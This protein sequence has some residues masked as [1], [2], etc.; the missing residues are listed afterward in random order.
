MYNPGSHAAIFRGVPY[1]MSEKTN[2]ITPEATLEGDRSPV[3]AKAMPEQTKD[4]GFL[5]I[6]SHLRFHENRPQKFGIVLQLTFA[7]A[8]MFSEWLLHVTVTIR[9]V[10]QDFH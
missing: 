1:A 6:P 4:F 2:T 3:E 5:P 8:T 10:D 9:K 7:A